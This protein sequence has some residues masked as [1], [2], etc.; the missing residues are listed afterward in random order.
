MT[1]TY[2]LCREIKSRC[3]YCSR[4]IDLSGFASELF[5][6]ILKRLGKG[7]RIELEN[8][9]V[10]RAPVTPGRKGRG[11]KSNVSLTRDRRVIRFRASP[12]AKAKVNERFEKEQKEKKP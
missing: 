1:G 2:Q 7:D 12:A 3:P 9:G 10:F 6:R 5:R 4:S 8:F 11:L